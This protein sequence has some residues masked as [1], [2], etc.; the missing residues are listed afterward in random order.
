ML[1]SPAWALTIVMQPMRRH[2]HP[3]Q[4]QSRH[5]AACPAH[6]PPEALSAGSWTVPA[7][8]EHRHLDNVVTLFQPFF[9]ELRPARCTPP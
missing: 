6:C 1:E 2:I 5:A 7:Y 8:A 3:S 9:G 4:L